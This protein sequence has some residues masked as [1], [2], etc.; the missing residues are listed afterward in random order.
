MRELVIR[1]PKTIKN[2]TPCRNQR[3]TR[4]HEFYHSTSTY[5]YTNNNIIKQH[6]LVIVLVYIVV[7]L[8]FSN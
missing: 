1:Y 5:S 6:Y 7:L 3:I 2:K 4:V 8:E